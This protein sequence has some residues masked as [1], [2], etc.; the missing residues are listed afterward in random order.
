[1]AKPLRWLLVVALVVAP[2]ALAELGTRAY[3]RVSEG[4]WPQ[5]RHTTAWRERQVSSRLLFRRHPFLN[6]VPRANGSFSISRE[7]MTVDTEGPA[8]V[9]ISFNSLGYRSPERPRAKPDDVLRVLCA[10][11]STT[12]DTLAP[13]D[14]ETWPWQLEDALRADGLPVEVWNAGVPGWTSVESTVSL[15]LRDLDLEPDVIVL[16]VHDLQPLA[17]TPLAPQYD[18]GHAEIVQ[19]SLGF[20]VPTPHWWQ[21]SVALE[22]LGDL[23]S[24]RSG[25]R[26]QPTPFVDLS[27]V[28]PRD[29]LPPEALDVYE[30][31]LRSFLALARSRGADV[32]FATSLLRLRDSHAA[33]DAGY[34]GW[35]VPWL[36]PRAAPAAVE[37]MNEV[38]RRVAT[39]EDVVLADL[40]ADIAW[41]D[42]DFGDPFHIVRREPVV[43]LLRRTLT[44]LLDRRATALAAGGAAAAAPP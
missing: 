18:G 43:E 33:A 24:G 37:R 4:A 2:P 9:G 34:I 5:T 22:R 42:E 36:E 25:R 35:W 41:A 14:P 29:A 8:G 19:K 16:L 32:V 13:D 23:L 15:A 6:V 20:G 30:R 27:T 21:R 17:I 31:N 39:E 26:W 11:S 40:A 1:M 12:L 3:L 38:M 28:R 7:T 10:G 44:P